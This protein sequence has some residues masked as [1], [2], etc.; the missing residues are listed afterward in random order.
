VR[1]DVRHELELH[2]AESR[3]ITVVR[4]AHATAGIAER[5][6]IGPSHV[7]VGTGPADVSDGAVRAKLAGE[8]SEVFVIGRQLDVTVEERDVWVE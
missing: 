6:T 1:L 7:P 4:E 5:L 3:E 2:L 8:R